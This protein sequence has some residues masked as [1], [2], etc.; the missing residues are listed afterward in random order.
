MGVY[1]IVYERFSVWRD[2][3]GEVVVMV[4][5]RIEIGLLGMVF[6]ILGLCWI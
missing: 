5:I 2:G 6:G 3:R 4:I 1:F